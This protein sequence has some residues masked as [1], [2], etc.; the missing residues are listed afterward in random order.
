MEVDEAIGQ[1]LGKG[2]NEEQVWR[3]TQLA[4]TKKFMGGDTIVRQFDRNSDL[5]I[6][7]DGSARIMTFQ[8]EFVAELGPGSIIG[9]ISLVDEQPRSANV[10]SAHGAT[11]AVIPAERLRTLLDGDPAIAATVYANIARTLCSRLRAATINL[12]GLMTS[13]AGRAA[14]L[15]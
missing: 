2:L 5:I 3:I 1:T 11:A 9:E 15:K 13:G 12:D 10:R 14:T 4:E 6:I 8:D 7:L